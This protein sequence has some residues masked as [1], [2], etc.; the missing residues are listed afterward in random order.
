MNNDEFRWMNKD[1]NVY[2][3]CSYIICRPI[4]VRLD[5]NYSYKLSVCVRLN[6]IESVYNCYMYVYI[7]I[8]A[9]PIL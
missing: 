1:N 8:R 9:T 7:T 3:C 4:L 2:T 6:L 5:A